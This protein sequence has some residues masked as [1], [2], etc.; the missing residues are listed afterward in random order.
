V[1]SRVRQHCPPYSVRRTEGSRVGVSADR[2][3]A[4][5]HFE[6]K[7]GAQSAEN[8]VPRK[9]T[10]P[11][12][13]VLWMRLPRVVLASICDEDRHPYDHPWRPVLL[14]SFWALG[15]GH[16]K[17][18]P[19]TQT[20]Y[21]VLSRR[22][23]YFALRLSSKRGVPIALQGASGCTFQGWCPNSGPLDKGYL[24]QQHLALRICPWPAAVGER[25]ASA[26]VT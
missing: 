23:P 2:A 17:G 26:C 8:R 4:G 10:Y 1:L 18:V 25:G 15:S 5:R 14:V 6:P 16:F 13:K 20:K 19:N 7:Y 3:S 11:P 21:P 24:C 22:I 12:P 9:G